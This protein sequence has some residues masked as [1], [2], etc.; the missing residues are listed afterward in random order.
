MSTGTGS[1][2]EGAGYINR[3]DRSGQGSEAGPSG[4]FQ[5]VAPHTMA[6]RIPS[7][8]QAPRRLRYCHPL[9]TK[10]SLRAESEKTLTVALLAQSSSGLSKLVRGKAVDDEHRCSADRYDSRKHV[11]HE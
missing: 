9:P 11:Q 6:A 5:L 7:L 4:M 1:V 2:T 10:S 8:A 3:C